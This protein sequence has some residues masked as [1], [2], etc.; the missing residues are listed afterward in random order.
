MTLS[1]CL[2]IVLSGCAQANKTTDPTQCLLTV[3]IYAD[4]SLN[5]QINNYLTSTDLARGM[6]G[7]FDK[8][9]VF[10]SKIKFIDNDVDNDKYYIVVADV[11]QDNSNGIDSTKNV[12]TYAFKVEKPS[13]HIIE[14]ALIA[15]G[16]DAK[17]RGGALVDSKWEN[18]AIGDYCDIQ[19]KFQ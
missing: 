19:E 13:N 4:D 12:T 7:L 17:F 16:A 5:K 6:D 10:D 8:D 15:N 1:L 14:F 11:R 3:G 18:N 9:I 2:L